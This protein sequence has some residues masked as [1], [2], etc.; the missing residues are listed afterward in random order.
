[1]DDSRDWLNRMR[2]ELR[3]QKKAISKIQWAAESLENSVEEQVQLQRSVKRTKQRR[4][5]RTSRPRTGSTRRSNPAYVKEGVTQVVIDHDGGGWMHVHVENI[6]LPV[7]LRTSERLRVLVLVL[8]GKVSRVN[9]P[10]SGLVPFKTSG[11]LREA[12]KA[13]SGA[14]ISAGYLQNLIQQLRDLLEDAQV[15]PE[16]VETGGGGYRFRLQLDGDVH[17]ERR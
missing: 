6:G 7:L 13:I 15:N 2:K 17:E 8:C 10:E 16:L 14:E 9:N 5:H 3:R 1:M 12:F 4:S 11:E